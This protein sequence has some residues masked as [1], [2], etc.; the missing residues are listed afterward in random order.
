MRCHTSSVTKI[1]YNPILNK[2]VSISKDNTIRIWQYVVNH[3]G[4]FPFRMQEQY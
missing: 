3:E 4:P 2:M 1:I